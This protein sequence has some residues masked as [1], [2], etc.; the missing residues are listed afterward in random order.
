MKKFIPTTIQSHPQQK[1]L[2]E[3][4]TQDLSSLLELLPKLGIDKLFSAPS[5]SQKQEN[6]ITPSL[7]KT[8]NSRT[9]NTLERNRNT[10]QALINKKSD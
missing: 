6:I 4:E 2:T 9:A 5:N 8:I 3:Q 1:H 7:K 10:A